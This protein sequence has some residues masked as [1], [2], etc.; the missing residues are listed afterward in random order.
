[1]TVQMAD[2]SSKKIILDL[3]K[4][5]KELIPLVAEKFRIASSIGYSIFGFGPDRAHIPLEL[6]GYLPTQ[7]LDFS[8]LFFKRR[9]LFFTRKQVADR[10]S[11]IAVFND[12]K[13]HVASARYIM[14]V[15][16][17]QDLLF[18]QIY[19]SGA[20]TKEDAE[21]AVSIMNVPV[22]DDKRAVLQLFK[23]RRPPSFEE[24]VAGY[25]TVLHKI[26]NFGCETWPVQYAAGDERRYAPADC[27]IGP[28]R[29]E[30][31]A[32]AQAVYSIPYFRFISCQAMESGIELKTVV[33][34]GVELILRIQSQTPGPFKTALSGYWTIA[35]DFAVELQTEGFFQ[36]DDSSMGDDVML[37]VFGHLYMKSEDSPTTFYPGSIEE[38]KRVIGP[39]LANLEK[40]FPA[41]AKGAR[42]A[43]GAYEADRFDQEGMLDLIFALESLVNKDVLPHFVEPEK[44]NECLLSISAV[45]ITVGGLEKLI[46]LLDLCAQ[47]HQVIRGDLFSKVTGQKKAM[48]EKF[49]KFL[50]QAKSQLAN[51]F[52]SIRVRPTDGSLI[53]Q[54]QHN[55]VRLYGGLSELRSFVEMVA[56]VSPGC[57]IGLAIKHFQGVLRDLLRPLR[58]AEPPERLQHVYMM[59][60]MLFAVSVVLTFGTNLRS[61]PGLQANEALFQALGDSLVSLGGLYMQMHEIR[62]LLTLRPFSLHFLQDGREMMVKLQ[63]ALCSCRGCS[64]LAGTLTGEATFSQAIAFANNYVGK[65]IAATD[66]CRVEPFRHIP[67]SQTVKSVH[68]MLTDA[69]VAIAGSNTHVTNPRDKEV[70]ERIKGYAAQLKTILSMMRCCIQAPTRTVFL[71]VNKARQILGDIIDN[72]REFSGVLGDGTVF[73]TFSGILNT[74]NGILTNQTPSKHDL[75]EHI[76]AFDKAVQECD[77]D[78]LDSQATMDMLRTLRRSPT[79][80]REMELL[81]T[82]RKNI[83]ASFAQGQAAQAR[84]ARLKTA[85]EEMDSL[86]IC[87][88]QLPIRESAM[89]PPLIITP[90]FRGQDLDMLIESF[91]KQLYDLALFFR[92]L[93]TSSVFPPGSEQHNIL[94]CWEDFFSGMPHQITIFRK[95]VA[96]LLSRLKSIE[97]SNSYIDILLKVIRP[98]LVDSEA[99]VKQMNQFFANARVMVEMIA[100]PD[101][102]ERLDVRRFRAT[103]LPVMDE[104]EKI[105]PRMVTDNEVISAKLA[106]LHQ[107]LSRGVPSEGVVQ[108]QLFAHSIYRTAAECLMQIKGAPE[109][110]DSV[111]PLSAIMDKIAQLA[112]CQESEKSETAEFFGSF[113]PA[114]QIQ[115]VYGLVLA[116]PDDVS[117]ELCSRMMGMITTVSSDM[118]ALSIPIKAAILSLRSQ[119]ETRPFAID[120]LRIIVE[121]QLSKKARAEQR[122]GMMTQ[123][124]IMLARLANS[125][126]LEFK[127]LKASN[128]GGDRVFDF[129]LVHLQSLFDSFDPE[130]FGSKRD[131]PTLCDCYPLFCDLRVL[132][133]MFL[134]TNPDVLIQGKSERYIWFSYQLD[135]AITFHFWSALDSL[136]KPASRI[137]LAK[138]CRRSYERLQKLLDTFE[139]PMLFCTCPTYKILGIL[140]I[141]KEIEDDMRVVIQEFEGP[142]GAKASKRF[143]AIKDFRTLFHRWATPISELFGQNSFAVQ[144]RAAV[145]EAKSTASKLTD[146]L[147]VNPLRIPL[148]I[149]SLFIR[150]AGIIG[151]IST[152]VERLPHWQPKLEV[153]RALYDQVVPKL[154]LMTTLEQ[155]S[156]AERGLQGLITEIVDR[157]NDLDTFVAQTPEP[158]Y[159]KRP[160]RSGLLSRRRIEKLIAA[161]EKTPIYAVA[162]DACHQMLKLVEDG[163]STTNSTRVFGMVLQ[164][165]EGIASQDVG[166]VRQDLIQ[167]L[168]TALSWLKT[169]GCP[170]EEFLQMIPRIIAMCVRVFALLQQEALDFLGVPL[171]VLITQF[172]DFCLEQE[173]ATTGPASQLLKL[174]LGKLQMFLSIPP[175]AVKKQLSDGLMQILVAIQDQ[176]AKALKDQV[177]FISALISSAI[178]ANITDSI[179]T[180]SKQVI[181]KLQPVLPKLVDDKFDLKTL[182]N[183]LATQIRDAKQGIIDLVT[184]TIVFLISDIR[185]C[186]KFD[187]LL[188]MRDQVMRFTLPQDVLDG[189]KFTEVLMKQVLEPVSHLQYYAG[190]AISIAQNPTVEQCFEFVK[191]FT[192]SIRSVSALFTQNTPENLR[193]FSRYCARCTDF[194][195]DLSLNDDHE[196]LFAVKGE[197][198]QSIQI[199]ISIL[200]TFAEINAARARSQVEETWQLVHER[201]APE[202]MAAIGDFNARTSGLYRMNANRSISDKFTKALMQFQERMQKFLDGVAADLANLIKIEFYVA[203]AAFALCQILMQMGQPVQL[204]YDRD[205]LARMPKRITLPEVLPGSE[206]EHPLVQLLYTI[207]NN[208]GQYR[209]LYWGSNN[210]QLVTQMNQFA[211]EVTAILAEAIRVSYTTFSQKNMQALSE[212][213][214]LLLAAANDFLDGVKE[215]LTGEP[216]WLNH[217][218]K[219]FMAIPS[220]LESLRQ[221]AEQVS[222]IKERSPKYVTSCG[223]VL[224]VFHA[225]IPQLKA[226]SEAILKLDFSEEREL[227]HEMVEVLRQAGEHLVQVMLY[228]R[229]EQSDPMPALQ[230]GTSMFSVVRAILQDPRPA[231]ILGFVTQMY[232]FAQ[233]LGAATGSAQQAPKM[234]A[235]AEKLVGRAKRLYLTAVRRQEEMGKRQQGMA[236]S[237]LADQELKNYYV[238]KLRLEARVQLRKWKLEALQSELTQMS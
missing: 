132:A 186:Q 49:G 158:D 153:L 78:I 151:L 133:T 226:A 42:K 192:L 206:P 117:Y 161:V 230:T 143:E 33:S 145:R 172:N 196:Q 124:A 60:R 103:M 213:I 156:K 64:D 2:G 119:P 229:D 170:L 207:A 118:D 190:R 225:A 29:I 128:S 96:T 201:K 180:K 197:Q 19:A 154:E 15:E 74:L 68:D 83:Q 221:S 200:A 14:T 102:G 91:A 56:Q 88:N 53:H 84:A 76:G 47:C 121:T 195:D 9:F 61:D 3:T 150:M 184:A 101:E 106:E 123:F 57:P 35:R 40:D 173:K 114:E 120:A 233:D 219:A 48:I 204:A 13:A 182:P 237:V 183:L 168:Q 137:A 235:E 232:G 50:K 222:V 51:A 109:F 231:T 52:S 11:A 166:L 199:T 70:L 224:N 18:Y 171:R 148:L 25:L 202:L 198:R 179:I 163:H 20:A 138:H 214:E 236:L 108:V 215:K 111:K 110:N 58:P 59:H 44:I 82:I 69:L 94:H 169:G 31:I 162:R 62:K 223:Q 220:K 157:L 139:E 26:P 167:S 112:G 228:A 165:I 22:K 73:H 7:L 216:N 27:V 99:S 159:A 12:I 209:G 46:G 90:F 131:F 54:V 107:I 81:Q 71:P 30:I 210:A 176:D 144:I 41:L 188:D 134:S 75:T 146:A 38:T 116:D 187:L 8:N 1:V 66:A 164:E 203:E 104:V 100:H 238:E 37:R 28:R 130:V 227:A 141:L 178:Q 21:R 98:W 136:I 149:G 67:K 129:Y 4:S 77:K 86:I 79:P 155:A 113:L 217:C 32:A 55:L 89:A 17:R 65:C 135:M 36:E 105:L 45:N 39:A 175:G 140:A 193:V 6:E 23:A 218:E 181:V 115:E 234:H 185:N 191:L 189:K 85:L 126:K 43:L 97:N 63:R 80:D 174:Q 92:D 147:A 205:N 5:V 122:K 93:S 87:V 72:I 152:V 10:A 34:K 160:V 125:F 208:L 24:A 142:L 194:V 177:I 127:D 16:Q 95:E 211:N 212:T